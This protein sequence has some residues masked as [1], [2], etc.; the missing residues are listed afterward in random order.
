MGV[1]RFFSAVAVACALLVAAAA[2]S[3]RA[4]ETGAKSNIDPAEAQT[5]DLGALDRQFRA[6]YSQGKYAEAASIGE[7]VLKITE[8]GRGPDDL[9]TAAA[10]NN[11]A[12]VYGIQGRYE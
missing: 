12:L 2:I 11:I 1:W 6:L 10:L 3:S 7:R 8:Q 9:G 5:D 4:Q